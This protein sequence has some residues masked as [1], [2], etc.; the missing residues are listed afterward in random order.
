M[1]NDDYGRRSLKLHLEKKGKIEIKSRMALETKDDLSLA[2][3]PGVA[4]PCLEIAEDKEKAY[5]YTSKSN[6]VAVVTDGSAVL[7]LGNIGSM[8]S[9]PVMEGKAVLFKRF[10]GVDAF[11]IAIDTHD[12]QKIIETV[13]LISPVF[14]GINL[15]D[16]KAPECFAVEDALRAELD[17]PV[18]HDDQHGT[19]IVALAALINA[20]KVVG[21]DLKSLKILV[22]GAG[23]AG[24]AITNMLLS[25]GI[26]DILILDTK[27]AL[28]YCR[29][30]LK[31][32]QI[33]KG[34]ARQTNIECKG[35]HDGEKDPAECARCKRGGLAAVIGGRDVFIGVSA[36]NILTKEMVRDMAKN[37]I[38]FALANPVPEISYDE[39]KAAG[40]MIVGT[41]RSD[42]PNQINNVLAFPGIFR[43][44]LDARAK[45]ITRG[46]KLAA[47]E[48]IASCVKQPGVDAIIPSPF[49]PEVHR[50]VA[51]K[52]MDAAKKE[53]WSTKEIGKEPGK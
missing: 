14:G 38:V 19:A 45:D 1:A 41:G 46:M 9:I 15:E 34:I 2:Y 48:A 49:D 26:T 39:A 36:P 21:K 11:P 8:A 7:G 12:V 43:G 18:F 51:R 13:K 40:A 22:N 3:T 23:A 47:A 10:G 29:D 27:G 6:M 17:I 20:S 44:A 24:I 28:Y 52:V 16:I 53:D 33:K 50:M 32:N 35:K 30:D 37:P 42:Y 5:S 25:Y 31:L 4:Q